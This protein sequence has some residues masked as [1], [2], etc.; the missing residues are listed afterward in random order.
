MWYLSTLGHCGDNIIENQSFLHNEVSLT[1]MTTY[2]YWD[3]LRFVRRHPSQHRVSHQFLCFP[4]I[5]HT[6]AKTTYNNIVLFSW[7]DILF[8][9]GFLS[10]RWMQD[11]CARYSY[12]ACVIISNK[13]D[14]CDSSH[15]MAQTAP[16]S[17]PKSSQMTS[18][19]LGSMCQLLDICDTE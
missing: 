7:F 2:L 4:H 1:G 5:F 14:M 6:L 17:W 15:F 16:Y 10:S 13:F 8:Q 19:F 18:T 9:A 3:V 12:S 11:T